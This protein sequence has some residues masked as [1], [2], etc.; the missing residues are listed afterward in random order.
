MAD[1]K[2]KEADE[3][4]MKQFDTFVRS[5]LFDEGNKL[6][7]EKSYPPLTE[8]DLEDVDTLKKQL[9]KKY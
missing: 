5:T 8:T 3:E 6:R 1:E 7:E 2:R 4:L 9:G